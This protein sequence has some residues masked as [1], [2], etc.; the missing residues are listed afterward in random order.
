MKIKKTSN[1]IWSEFEKGK[2][3][4]KSIELYD[5]V[6]RCENFYIG[7][8]WEGLNAPD[9]PKPV[10]NV[11]KRVVSYF[12][13]MIVSDDIGILLDPYKKTK[14]QIIPE[15]SLEPI[16]VIKE[17]LDAK[18]IETEIDK[19]IER[20]NIKP[21]ARKIV[22]NAAIDGDSYLY[23]YY[24][25]TI[26]AGNG[27]VGGIETE[28]LDNT[29]VIFGNPYRS[30]I[31]KQ[32]YIL[33]ATPCILSDVQEEAKRN[34]LPQDKISQIYADNDS[35]VYSYRESSK[36]E[37]CTV[38][39]KLWREN[40]TIHA[41]KTTKDVVIRSEWDTR[42]TRYPISNMIWEEIRN[43]YH[44]KGAVSQTIPNQICINQLY[45]MA[46]HW[47]KTSAIPKTLY[48]S[49]KIT[50][51]TNKVGQAIGV[52]GN[53]NE[54]V[55]SSTPGS[56]M[57]PQMMNIINGLLQHTAEYMGANDAAL[58]NIKPDNAAAIIATQNATAMPLELQKLEYYRFM[59][60]C[61]RIIIDII[62]TDYGPRRTSIVNDGNSY[63]VMFD[64]K[65]SSEAN[66]NMKVE[67]GQSSYWSELTQIQTA[68][69]LL[70][71]G[72]IPDAETYLES[73]PDK[74]IR[75][76]EKLLNQIRKKAKQAEMM[77]QMQMTQPAP[78]P[79]MTEGGI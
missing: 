3:Y 16:E 72:I 27:A 37:L 50:A 47:A 65:T 26:D 31:Q 71:K 18:V 29:S 59:E 57:N 46:I 30:E 55:A 78:V 40:G 75:N 24:D 14:E 2:S 52:I 61:V 41:I 45:A 4:N 53:P 73:I 20:C 15:D 79:P 44:G 25:G 64:F 22:R 13:A 17:E 56:N 63:D 36:S 70:A 23:F 19:T 8:Q 67:I 54:V 28:V 68:D 12:I 32:P 49:T 43:S 34:G 21:Q 76:K 77:A 42:Y 1:E 7:R 48:D 10:I 33:I 66:Y 9:L 11:T 5:T 39:T 58:G 38:I 51:W 74:F 6:K 35:D 60:E 69:N 62:K